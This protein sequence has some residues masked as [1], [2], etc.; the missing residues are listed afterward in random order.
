MYVD[1]TKCLGPPAISPLADILV[2]QL[3][4]GDCALSMTDSTTS[5]EGWMWKTNFKEEMDH[6]QATVR[7]EV[8]RS[9]ATRYMNHTIWEYSQWFL[10]SQNNVAD[11]LSQD[12]DR[13]D[14]ELT[15]ILFTH[16][17][18]QIPSTFKIVPLPNKIVCWV[19]LLLQKLPMQEQYR[20]V[21]T[22]TMLGI[23][24]GGKNI[25]SP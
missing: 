23:G 22:K 19:T 10:G 6:V 12:M 1:C 25:V 17:P 7:I 16:V 24:D 9:H 2:G 20:E 21:H 18:S 8:A 13:V 14:A 4:E 5:A 3:K 15:Q 11:A